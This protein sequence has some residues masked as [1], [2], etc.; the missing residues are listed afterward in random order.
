MIFSVAILNV[1][2]FGWIFSSFVNLC[3]A[4]SLSLCLSVS[5]S[6][7]AISWEPLVDCYRCCKCLL[8]SMQPCAVV[9]FLLRHWMFPLLLLSFFRDAYLFIAPPLSLVYV[10]RW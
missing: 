9:V 6:W 10:I 5:L 7:L 1:F 3:F 8:L 2:F 4:A